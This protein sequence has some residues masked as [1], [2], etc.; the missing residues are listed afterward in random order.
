M[1]YQLHGFKPCNPPP[2][3][4]LFRLD[5]SN[6]KKDPVLQQ[7]CAVVDPELPNYLVTAALQDFCILFYPILCL[8]S[9]TIIAFNKLLSNRHYRGKLHHV[10]LY[11]PNLP[12]HWAPIV[13][14]L[15]VQQS[16][17]SGWDPACN[18]TPGCE[19]GN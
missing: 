3:P 7:T 4:L 16:E 13:L 17:L 18:A 14:A 8:I 1:T 9:A 6:S 2:Q 11:M 10:L 15:A 5:R 19:V 12:R